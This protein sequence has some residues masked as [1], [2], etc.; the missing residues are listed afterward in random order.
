MNAK[1]IVGI[2]GIRNLSD[3]IFPKQIHDHNL[4]VFQG[5]NLVHYIHLERVSRSKYDANMHQHIE[6]IVQKL[7]LSHNRSIVLCFADHELGKAFSSADGNI[8]FKPDDQRNE[9][10]SL[11]EGVSNWY[12]QNVKAFSI[13]HELAH[14][15]S[16]IPFF[17]Q[18]RPE[19]LMIHYDGGASI[20][21]F[22][23]W[24]YRNHKIHNLFHHWELKKYTSFF[25]ANALVFR[26]TGTK[27]RFHNSVPGKLMGLAA[28]GSYN[29]DI[30]VWLGKNKYFS[31]IWS[32]P[33][34]F[35]L[36]LKSDWGLDIQSVDNRNSFL[37]NLAATLHEMFVRESLMEIV[38][39]KAI[40]KFRHL[41]FTG[42][43][44]LNIKLNSALMNSGEFDEVFI[45]PCADDSGLSLG[46]AVAVSLAQGNTIRNPG[47]H[48][49]NYLLKT[50]EIRVEKQV[51]KETASLIYAN[52]IVGICNGFG[53]V[54][55]RALGNRSLLARADSKKLSERISMSLKG[56]EWYRPVAPV[57]LRENAEYYTGCK[58]F[59]QSAGYM[60]FDFKIRSERINEIEGVVHKDNTSRIQVIEQRYQNPFLYDLLKECHIRYGIRALINTSFNCKGEPIV[61]NRID[62]LNTA[63][64]MHL[65]AL[66]ID[67]EILKFQY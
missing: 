64:R 9:I 10:S 51:I 30:E 14:I 29:K 21:N 42:G 18:F 20:S 1:I 4:A 66:I 54:G 65:D 7:N 16:C 33:R 2:Y 56:R 26:L 25:N 5:G 27:P 67:G 50:K 39:I 49:N 48:L 55:P 37:K 17:G 41:Y 23:A 13:S 61:H 6:A 43:C 62:A 40:H 44:A 19:S 36:Q 52:S 28:Y 32:S 45:P 15:Y 47:P 46:A 34:Q 24:E 3:A 63:E 12:G 22:S 31:D 60:L 11:R 35:F 38:K 53:E 58:E 59:H 57:M 8:Q